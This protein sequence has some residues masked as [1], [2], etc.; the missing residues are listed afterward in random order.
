MKNGGGVRRRSLLI[1]SGAI[2]AAAAITSFAP[3]VWSLQHGADLASIHRYAAEQARKL[4]AG[5]GVSLT[6]LLPAGSP[7]NV[8]PVADAFTAATGI[9]FKF[10][11]TPVDEINSQMIIDSISGGGSFDLALP[12]TF[13][14][15]DLVSAGALANLDGFARKYEPAGFQDDALFS[16]GDYYKGSLY[17]YQTDGDTYL[18]FY[19]KDCLENA[20]EQKRFAD[21][22]GYPLRVPRTWQELDAQMAYFQRPEENM[23]GGALFRTP[24]YIAWEFWIR[25]HAKGY[26]PFD[27]KLK[28]QINNEAG[29]EAL[30]DLV[31]ASDNLYPKARTNGLFENWKAFAEG[32]IYCNIGWG[33]TQKFL[34][35]DKSKIKGNLLFGA[36]P[37]GEVDGKL[38]QVP[39]F[40]WGWNYTVSSGS[41]EPELAY[42]FALYACSPKMSTHAVREAS[43]YFD[44]FRSAHYADA[45]IQRTYTPEFLTAHRESMALS[46]PD[47]YLPGQG[48]Y[49][50]A[51]RQN[52]VRANAGQLTTKRALDL[53]AQQWEQTTRRLG[54]KAQSEQWAYLRRSYPEKVRQALR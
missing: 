27:T 35:G 42:L 11:E 19:K 23:F 40:N 6:I 30:S 50:D 48:E 52:L 34:N 32:N 31:A 25:F 12:A 51:L 1:G 47:L 18:M 33:G 28:P 43:G 16:L 53:T 21:K 49:F 38:V 17:G 22:H 39:Y 8:R 10:V 5:R 54:R 41:K 36:T 45:A 20:D 15:P 44:P 24:N 46:I 14:V 13:G 2:G 3:Q 7:A 37:G 4:A 29:V 26:W 9:K